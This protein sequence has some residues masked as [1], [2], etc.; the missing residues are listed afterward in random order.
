MMEEKF[1]K[2]IKLNEYEIDDKLEK[3]LQNL[4]I[5][6]FPNIYPQNRIY[7]KQ[8]P[9]FR[10]LAYDN[11][12]L[13]AHVGLDYRVMSLNGNSIK[14]LGIIDLCVKKEYQ[15]KNVASIL[16][17]KIDEFARIHHIDFLLLFADV[18]TVY[19]RNGFTT[20]KNI[21]K[22]LKISEYKTVGIGEEEVEGLMIKKIGQKDW[23]D[24]YLDMLGYLY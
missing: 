17:N 14:V 12:T 10:Y 20:V 5:E 19:A 21:C 22:W 23:E 3:S 1:I 4:L 16:L 7:F 8:L 18:E 9:H 24:G 6:S 11:E 13:I 2:I 15:G